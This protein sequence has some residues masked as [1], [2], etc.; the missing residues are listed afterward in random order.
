M[1]RRIPES[2]TLMIART[3]RDP[4]VFYCQPIAIWLSIAS[5]LAI[6]GVTFFLG[7]SLGKASNRQAELFWPSTRSTETA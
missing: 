4:I 2:Y 3:G 5:L 7:W 6:L 1:S